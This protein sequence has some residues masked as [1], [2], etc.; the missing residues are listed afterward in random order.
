MTKKAIIAAVGAG[1][2]LFGSA[3]QMP[4]TKTSGPAPTNELTAPTTSA[5]EV[6]TVPSKPVEISG[7]GD[8]VKTVQLEPGGY[9]VEYKNSTG[10]L[11]VQPVERDGTTGISIINAGDDAGVVTYASTG[12]VTLQFQNGGDWSLRFVP[13]S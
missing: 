2:C 5:A 9:T 10:Y 13:L 3:C 7:S 8:T 12:P 1:I 4:A 6:M 11:I